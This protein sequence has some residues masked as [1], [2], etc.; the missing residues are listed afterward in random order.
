MQAD[1]VLALEVREGQ[2]TGA[3]R[4]LRENGHVPGTLYGLADPVNVSI[5]SNVLVK[6]LKR[7]GLRTRIYS[8]KVQGKEN[9]VIFRD[10]Q[11]HPVTGIAKH[12]D[13]SASLF[14]KE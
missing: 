13:V 7:P 9:F 4:Q 5:P 6:E 3:A 10:I 14:L 12:F 1:S 11:R 2:G 8:A